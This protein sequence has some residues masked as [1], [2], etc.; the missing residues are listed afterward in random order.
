MEVYKNHSSCCCSVLLHY[1]TSQAWNNFISNGFHYLIV[2]RLKHIG[3][4]CSFVSHNIVRL[5]ITDWPLQFSVMVIVKSGNTKYIFSQI[6]EWLHGKLRC[7]Q[8]NTAAPIDY[9]LRWL[10]HQL[11]IGF[12]NTAFCIQN[13]T[14]RMT[15]PSTNLL[16]S[17][18]TIQQLQLA[19]CTQALHSDLP[20]TEGV[21]LLSLSTSTVMLTQNNNTQ[22]IL[23]NLVW[24]MNC[25]LKG[26]H[27]RKY[28]H[29]PGLGR[30]VPCVWCLGLCPVSMKAVTDLSCIVR[31]RINVT[32]CKK[33]K[34]LLL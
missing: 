8:T 4:R 1:F 23:N 5:S 26:I 15:H 25:I 31:D 3:S 12:T 16:P 18:Y 27:D 33:I 24:T 6:S 17:T 7:K 19:T 30:T 32:I 2:L 13:P 29:S 11:L 34:T 20:L 9:D 28:F 10:H 14:D 21:L 22:S